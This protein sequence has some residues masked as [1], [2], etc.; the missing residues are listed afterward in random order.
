MKLT[1]LGTSAGTPSR[2]RNVTSI[3]LQWMQEGSVWLFDCGEGTQQQILRSPLSLSRIQRIFLTHLHGDHLFGLPGLLSTRSL[4]DPQ[5]GP[6]GVHGPE[7]VGKFI[8]CALEVSRARL[9]YPIMVETISEGLVYDDDTRYVYCRRLSHG[10]MPSFGYAIVEKP[11]PG[12]F[13]AEMA[14]SLGIPA[15]PLYG[16]LKAGETI[17]LAD[18]RAIEG[19]ALVGPTRPGR[20]VV[21]CGDTGQTTN[22]VQLAMGADVLVHEATFG[23]AEEERAKLQGHSTAQ[24]AAA[25]AR[26][27]GVKALILT[28]ISARYESQ[29]RS[30]LTALLDE[31]RAIFP[32]TYLAEDFWTFDI[33]AHSSPPRPKMGERQG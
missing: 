23:N 11:K 9:A 29:D 19:S 27:A 13:D 30:Q 2:T 20:K 22:T 28:H 18:G 17:T 32:N 1:F 14:A 4:I 8:A 7:G 3:A 5:S 21:I 33:E 24:M 31:A 6:I 16:K 12:E 25:V 26:D 10:A 15:G